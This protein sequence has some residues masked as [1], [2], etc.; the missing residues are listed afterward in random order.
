MGVEWL[1]QDVL[2]GEGE[3]LVDI[4]L[5][6]PG[7]GRHGSSWRRGSRCSGSADSRRRSPGGRAECS[8][9]AASRRAAGAPRGPAGG[10]P[11]AADAPMARQPD[12]PHIG[13][14]EV[15]VHYRFHPLAGQRVTQ[16]SQRSLRGNPI[17]VVADAPG[18]RYH[19]PKWMTAPEAAQWA[20]RE[21]P[22][23]SLAALADLRELVSA[24]LDKPSP[25]GKG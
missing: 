23:L 1:E 10:R 4:E 14:G 18:K 13:G 20:I 3:L 24:L 7:S 22:R 6:G 9:A 19:I 5:A 25:T 21:Q 11:S 15:T 16:V 12:T 17:V 2:D 8:S